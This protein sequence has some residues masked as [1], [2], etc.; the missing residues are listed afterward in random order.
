LEDPEVECFAPAGGVLD[1]GEL[2]QQTRLMHEHSIEDPEMECFAQHREDMDFE[3]LLE[4]VRGVGEPSL[5][6]T[7][8]ESFAQ[9]GYDVDF[10]ELVEQAK[11]ILDPCPE[12]QAECGE[13]TELPFPTPY[14]S[15]V[16]LPELI[17]GSKWVGPIHVWPRWPSVTVGRKKNNELFQT[18]VQRG[19]PGCIHNSKLKA[20]IRKDH[21][22][23]P[24][25]DPLVARSA[26]YSYYCVFDGYSSYNHVTLDPGKQENTTLTSAF[27]VFAGCHT[28][29]ESCNTPAI[30][31]LAEDYK[32]SAYGRQPIVPFSFCCHLIWLSYF[33]FVVIVFFRKSVYRSS[34]G[35]CS[36]T[37]HPTYAAHLVF[38]PN[39][40]GTMCHFSLGVG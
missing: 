27:G 26:E 36:P 35:E 14:S 1:I 9:L 13:I 11:A 37:L 33:V 23:P 8:L 24:F 17:F 30:E 10:D 40:L 39:T 21:F 2:L 15:A 19:W 7:M 20:I 29:S 25:I 12:S 34:L 38:Y 3:G 18:H 32:L 22:P 16:E 31:S 28:P 6:D 5:K 4:P